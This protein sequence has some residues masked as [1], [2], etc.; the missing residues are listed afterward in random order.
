MSHRLLFGD[1]GSICADSAWLWVNS[2]DWPDWTID[3]VTAIDDSPASLV[4]REL[5]RPEVADQC[6]VERVDGDPRWVLHKYGHDHDLIVVG[7]KGQGLMKRLHLGSTSE[8]LMHGPPAPVVIVRSG[9]R[10]QRILL[11]HDG[12]G[13]ARSA[14]RAVAELPWIGH[15]TV[16]IVVVLDDHTDATPAT[17]AAERLAQVAGDVIVEVLKPDDLQVFYRP[18]DLLLETAAAWEPDLIAMGSRG[19]SA[20]ESLNEIGLHRA[21]STASAIAQH[22]SGNVLLATG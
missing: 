3:V 22:S 7:S 18:R 5:M 14:E 16:K 2:H 1:D 6:N 13:H 21:G 10:T 8:W 12:S 11:A 4:A 15:V 19:L 20:W 9:H 17:E